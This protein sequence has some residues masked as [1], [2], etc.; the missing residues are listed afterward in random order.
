MGF[1][2]SRP[3]KIS[4]AGINSI[5]K[6]VNTALPIIQIPT[7]L[8]LNIPRGILALLHIYK[9]LTSTMKQLLTICMMLVFYSCFQRS[10]NDSKMTAIN[11]PP[12]DSISKKNA[13]PGNTGDSLTAL[14]EKIGAENKI[15]QNEDLKEL[16]DKGVFSTIH[17][18]SI[19]SLPEHIQTFFKNTPKNELLA[20]SK[21]YLFQNNKDDFAFV[22]YDKKESN[23]S[24]LVYDASTDKYLELYKDL[25]VIN[26]LKSL[27][28]NS[29]SDDLRLDLGQEI[30]YQREYL[31]KGPYNY[32]DSSAVK[33]ADISKDKNFVIKEGCL[34]KG[35]TKADF[36]NT[37]CI[38]TSSVYNNWACLKYDR[39]KNIFL[40]FYAQAYAD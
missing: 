1:V 29:A 19:T 32:L 20:Y 25:K 13:E 21:G 6:A 26:E 37:L 31:L 15:Q 36:K 28:C 39:S 3:P 40:I 4:I 16:S 8:H 30:V 34:S 17:S 33:I 10:N 38:S 11:P 24:I 23:I 9:M 2:G 5:P 27:D 22:I 14:M 35:T 7:S 12:A 18:K